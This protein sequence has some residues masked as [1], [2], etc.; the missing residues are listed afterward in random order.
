MCVCVAMPLD[1]QDL[2]SPTRDQ[3]QARGSESTKS[4]PL[5]LQG[6]S[7]TDLQAGFPL[8]SVKYAF[9]SEMATSTMGRALD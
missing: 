5:D 2:S 6:I 7:D 3:T 4:Q 9:L 8:G 1:F